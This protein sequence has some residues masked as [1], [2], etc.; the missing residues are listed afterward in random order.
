ME[1]RSP[2]SHI[3]IANVEAW[4]LRLPLRRPYKLSFGPIEA[5]D[6]L[7]VRA[8]LSDGREGWGEATLLTGY[9]DETI[10]QTWTLA[11]ELLHSGIRGLTDR[12]DSLDTTNPFLTTA[13]HTAYE[14]ATGS[15]LLNI[16]AKDKPAVS[17]P[18][19]GLLQCDDPDGVAD[20]VESLWAQGFRT[21]KLKVG[22]DAIED[23]KMVLATQRAANGRIRIRIDANQGYSA[24]DACMLVERV[25]P[26]GIEL[27]EQPCA[28]HDW[29][30]H[31]KVVA[32]ARQTGLPLML[33][34][35]IYSLREIERAAEEKA[36]QF[37][38]VK[39][40]KFNSLRKLTDAIDRIHALGMTPVLGNGVANELGCWM[41]ACVAHGRIANA[42]EMN[43]FTK[44]LDRL[45][46]SPLQLRDGAIELTHSRPQL[47]IEKIGKLAV[48]YLRGSGGT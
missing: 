38:K 48:A 42:G 2:W 23:A 27:F 44:P 9:T 12:L 20:E 45:F 8:T 29:D 34:E 4:L 35:S 5:F 7:L 24:R 3:D 19:L 30:S 11:G 26:A 17:V 28:S 36:A 33:D 18:V 13:F 39:L 32:V 1:I 41:E 47:D 16:V 22:F 43:G 37:V 14:M 15:E 10:D 46:A 31:A 21:A 6:T 25:D 40:M